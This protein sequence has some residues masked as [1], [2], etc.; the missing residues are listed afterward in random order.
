MVEPRL[1][2]KSKGA[3]II[4][5]LTANIWVISVTINSVDKESYVYP[6]GSDNF[7]TYKGLAFFLVKCLFF[8]FFQ[9]V[10]L[11]GLDFGCTT[12][13][14]FLPDIVKTPEPNVEYSFKNKILR[15][16]TLS[17][18]LISFNLDDPFCSNI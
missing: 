16:V 15:I 13:L 5:K 6:Q 11:W 18:L 2:F 8:F 17:L 3:A 12:H 14:N 1:A 9:I 7:S 4:V 10:A